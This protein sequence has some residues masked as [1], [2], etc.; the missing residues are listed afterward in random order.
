MFGGQSPDGVD[1]SGHDEKQPQQC[2]CAYVAV[3]FS[4]WLAD[5]ATCLA[6]RHVLRPIFCDEQAQQDSRDDQHQHD[7]KIKHTHLPRARKLFL[8]LD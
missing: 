2:F 1:H 7:Q 3:G 4:G 5:V 6:E 8:S